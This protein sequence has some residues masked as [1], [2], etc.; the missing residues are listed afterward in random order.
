MADNVLKPL[1][2]GR[3]VDV[4]MLVMLIGAIGGMVT[5]GITGLFVGAVV[6]AVGYKIFMEWV[7][8]RGPM[9]SRRCLRH[10]RRTPHAR[11]RRPS[12]FS[13]PMISG[14][15]PGARHRDARSSWRRP[16]C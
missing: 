14:R 4:P 13:D 5:G 15:A 11:T 7:D 12:P 8:S 3:G 10:R 9:P 16:C 2:L 6:L 1:L